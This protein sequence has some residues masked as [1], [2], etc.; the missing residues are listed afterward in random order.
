MT[1]PTNI[2]CFE[3][4][5]AALLAELYAEFPRP[6]LVLSK[7]FEARMVKSSL[8]SEECVWGE[9][10]GRP[11]ESLVASTLAWICE[12]GMARYASRSGGK[13]TGVVLTAKGFNAL[14]SP[15]LPASG[16]ETNGQRIAKFAKDSI[17]S[18]I[19]EAIGA[20]VRSTLQG[21]A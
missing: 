11:N 10:C 14:N 16:Q 6:M 1:T 9:S 13:F 12:E 8:I 18:G 19:S 7:D 4:A 2:E 3:Y 17:L 5:A 20:V 15:V 21:A